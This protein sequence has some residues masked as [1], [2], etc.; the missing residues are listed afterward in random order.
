MIDENDIA[1]TQHKLAH[2][3]C[4]HIQKAIEDFQ[5][6]QDLLP[7]TILFA[8]HMQGAAWTNFCQN[9]GMSAVASLDL[10]VNALQ[11]S[12]ELQAYLELYKPRFVEYLAR[13]EA[14][15]LAPNTFEHGEA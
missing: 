13:I 1:E 7:G 4:D 14:A 15:D 9:L 11:C 6:D 8:L 10:A 5:A 2:A 3:L 12:G